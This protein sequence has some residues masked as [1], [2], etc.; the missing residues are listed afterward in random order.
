LRTF[1]PSFLTALKA[2]IVCFGLTLLSTVSKGN[3]LGQ[4]GQPTD[5]EI[6]S[7]IQQL[8]NDEGR[9]EAANKLVEI[10][11]KAIPALIQAFRNIKSH[12]TAF[13]ILHE[14]AQRYGSEAS[15]AVP[16]FIE[17]LKDD[18]I[19]I[20]P[21]AAAALGEI[22]AASRIAI[23]ALTEA[24]QDKEH[25]EVLNAAIRALAT[26]AGKL[27]DEGE[28]LSARD[29]N[30][31]VIDLQAALEVATQANAPAEYVSQIRRSLEF[32]RLKLAERNK[33]LLAWVKRMYAARPWIILLLLYPLLFIVW[34]VISLVSPGLLFTINE[35]LKTSPQ[36]KVPR[37][38]IQLSVR[39]LLLLSPFHYCTRV[40]DAWVEDH[41]D[42]AREWFRSS[43][44]ERGQETHIPI[45]LKLNL[46]TYYG[47][48]AAELGLKF[49]GERGRLL[50]W[51]EGGVGK[52]N[53]AYEVARWATA[54]DS[55][56]RLAKHLMLP[57]L[58]EEV[59]SSQPETK[60]AS[61][62]PSELFTAIIRSKLTQ[63][64]KA[65]EAPD[66][67][68]VK[69]LLRRSRVLVIVDSSSGITED[70]TRS[71]N[72]SDAEFPGNALVITSRN[73]E[74]DLLRGE[75]PVRIEPQLLAGDALTSFITELLTERG[76]RAL[77]K[78]KD[79][80]K[81]C[82]K[83]VEIV[84]QTEVTALLAKLYVEY[85]IAFKNGRAADEPPGNIPELMI[86]YLNN[87]NRRPHHGE[88]SDETVHQDTKII[89][90]ECLRNSYRPATAT[91]E[92]VLKAMGGQD[93]MARLDYL[94]KKLRLVQEYDYKTEH[95]LIKFG[96]D[97]LA[98]YLAG[99]HLI[100]LC[101]PN[102]TLW[103]NFLA[104]AKNKLGIESFMQMAVADCVRAKG[105]A[106]GVPPFVL[107]VLEKG[108]PWDLDGLD[109][110]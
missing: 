61:P 78:D 30:Q 76:E 6:N 11:P 103:R 8:N 33:G 46:S 1:G 4:E 92:T 42:S 12:S 74:R 14:I 34:L 108:P 66:E 40:L 102:R 54:K 25:S 79:F 7:Y 29:L 88:H 27:Q 41:V 75:H 22:G 95:K 58:L 104:G 77:S 49:P 21:D 3:I 70:V 67:E 48:K 15:E 99:L 44:V 57:V 50:I 16:I 59:P 68:L 62:K 72:L 53:L 63:L 81:L 69:H 20:R 84:G 105:E 65:G 56:Q 10:G 35:K 73:E 71:L 19:S 5:A 64:I 91:R 17:A 55:S 39:T 90:W 86:S 107:E 31:A 106:A 32:L 87:I 110:N 28:K 18:Q 45:R 26:I 38:D 52:T 13:K 51:G 94:E 23:P 82:S 9:A 83:L 109:L 100:D 98:E 89:A 85:M 2:I 93:A 97:T 47:L 37:V 36:I 60:A 43:A 80:L 101:G 96:L 24:L